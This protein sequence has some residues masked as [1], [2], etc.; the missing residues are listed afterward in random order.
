[1]MTRSTIRPACAAFLALCLLVP[2]AIPAYSAAPVTGAKGAGAIVAAPNAQD[3]KALAQILGNPDD[4]TLPAKNI[5]LVDANG[6][7]ALATNTKLPLLLETKAK[8]QAPTQFTAV[9][10]MRPEN[11][12]TTSLSM[13]LLTQAKADKSNT[14][15]QFSVS[16]TDQTNA[17]NATL[18]VAGYKDLKP[19]RDTIYFDPITDVS[20]AWSEEMRSTIE[21]QIAQAPQVKETVFVAHCT[22]VGDSVRAWINGRYIGQQTLPQ[23]FEK[24]GGFKL[25]ATAN[26]QLLSL[27]VSPA[28]TTGNFEPISLDS[29][30]N[31]SRLA[32]DSV[33][34]SS[35]PG[36]SSPDA[37][38]TGRAAVIGGVPFE[39]PSA[40]AKDGSQRHVDVGQSWT[41]F[42]ALPGYISANHGAFGGRW[43]AAHRVDPA[44]IAMHVPTARYKALHIVA[45]A[46]GRPDSVPVL[47]AQFYRPDAGHPISFSANKIPALADKVDATRAVPVKLASGKEAMLYHITIPLNPDS[48]SWFSDLEKIGLEI[49]KQVQYYRAYPD[50]LEYSFHAG[51]LPSSV[52]LYAMTLE[53]ADLDVDI[54]PDTYG[55]VWTAP[56][57]PKYNIVLKND[58]GKPSKVRLTIDTAHSDASDKAPQTKE[59][60][61]PASNTPV[62]VPVE[63]K[64]TRYGL[65]EVTVSVSGD[66]IPDAVYKRNFAH[67]HPDTREQSVW[68]HGKGSIFGF[69]A[70]GGGHDT[71]T[72]DKEIPVMAAAGAETST[73]NYEKSPPEI[74]KLAEKHR[75]ISEA[76]FA[77][78]VMYI[79]GFVSASKDA[80]KWTPENPQAAGLAVVE[81]LKKLHMAPSPISRP[82]YVPFFA[83]PQIGNITTGIWPSHY[84]EEYTLSAPEQK[85]YESMLARYMASAAAIR[86]EWPSYKLLMPYGD[87]MNAAVFLKHSKEVA[88]LL[89]G[90]A[91]DLPGFERLPEQQINQVVLNRMYPVLGDVRKYKPDAYFVLIEGTH[92]SSKDI[93]TG[94]EG[95]AQISIRNYLTLMGYGISKFESGNSPF[96]CANYWGENHYGGGWMTRKPMSMP[97]LGYVQFATLTRN[98]NRA[99]FVKYIPTSS[100]STYCQQYKHYKTGAL[101]HTFWTIRGTRDVKLKVP[102]GASLTFVDAQDNETT[103]KESGG[104]I[105]FKINQF[106]VYVHG[107]TT[108]PVITLGEPDHSDSAPSSLAKKITN[109]A[110]GS[111]K[112]VTEPDEEYQKNKPLQIERFPGN[113]TAAPKDAP[114]AQGSKALAIH[115]GKQEKDRGVMP[116]F[117]TLKP[118]KPMTIEGKG[119]DLGLWVH[120]SSDWGRVVYSLRDAKGERWISVGAKEE[121]NCD[122]IH[123]WSNFC[124]DGWRYVTFP[125][126][127]NLPYD[128]YREKGSSW[129]GSYG[130]DGIVDLPLSLEKVII[131]RRPKAIV[132]NDLLPVKG[133]D[134]LLG[135]LNV[136]YA[137]AEDPS[138]ETVRQ[139][140]LR[141]PLPPAADTS[142][143]KN[144][145]KEMQESGVGAATTVLGVRDP[146]HEYD[147]T[148]C[149]VDFT[150]VPE[151]ATYDIWVSAYADGRGALKLGRAVAESGRLIRG[152]RPDREFW[153]FVTYTDKDGKVSKPSAGLKFILK[154]RFGYK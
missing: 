50:P 15:V 143:M 1:M 63:L 122:D 99:N 89:D 29:N 83:E 129:W 94:Q 16:S 100:T 19:S 96:D 51:G 33:L 10:R 53:R 74:I 151:A 67:L 137:S 76:A 64:P 112:L 104:I 14:S 121:W 123:G 9:F 141:M 21:S 5:S 39:F 57:T 79:N 97:K 148:R 68:E 37:I 69:W 85:T 95:Q 108:D 8:V 52:Q 119:S 28:A 132:G 138:K 127:S 17:I 56:Q 81:Y 11:K 110:D 106:P 147:G 103:L 55:N 91:L 32:G 98:L 120:A 34:A 58:S 60:T 124:F 46:D 92:V 109:M 38:A 105:T 125:L 54:V 12:G 25:S 65:H 72:V 45:V 117:T 48:F 23:D 7:S 102:A 40:N 145:I 131:E 3:A 62:S 115:L 22:L 26:V 142:A 77:G 27:R 44:R 6:Q 43:M 35:L 153:V 133:D 113:M 118:A 130:G 71:P 30:T 126:P 4:W 61:L 13:Q 18:A 139:S 154:D 149:H 82:S 31:T 136:E 114:K 87:P 66:G 36:Q 93:D 150:P 135:D 128:S 73:T 24:S 41:R 2:P 20:L 49:T 144:P 59:V 70:W 101:T 152:M 75:F 140:A 80:P 111:W 146:E 86:K 90:C 84:G 134:V 42:G 88:A 47:S 78:S 116:Y 107:L